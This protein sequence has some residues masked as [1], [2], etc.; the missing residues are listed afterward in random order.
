[1]HSHICSRVCVCVCV[2]VVC[3][4]GIKGIVGLFLTCL[5]AGGMRPSRKRMPTK[6][7]MMVEA[8]SDQPGVPACLNCCPSG[9]STSS[10]KVLVSSAEVH[11]PSSLSIDRFAALQ[12]VTFTFGGLSI[13]SWGDLNPVSLG[14][15]L[16]LA[17][18][19]AFTSVHISMSVCVCALVR[20]LFHVLSYVCSLGL[21]PQILDISPHLWT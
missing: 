21:Q 12:F 20:V 19:T 8:R 17:C 1:M 15:S 6:L 2:C 10:C 11:G 4:L 3:T 14:F 18:G 16:R 13:G 7:C 5:I 9:Y